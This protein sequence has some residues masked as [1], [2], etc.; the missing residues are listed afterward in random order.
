MFLRTNEVEQA[1]FLRSGTSGQW[2][3]KLTE[4]QKRLFADQLA[5]D[6][7]QFGYPI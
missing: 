2:Q 4:K 6:L 5:D 1:N 3:E 7:R